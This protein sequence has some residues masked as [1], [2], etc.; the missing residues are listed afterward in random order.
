MILAYRNLA[1]LAEITVHRD[2]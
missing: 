2:E 1:N